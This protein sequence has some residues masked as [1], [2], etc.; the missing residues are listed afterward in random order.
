MA[1]EY[2]RRRPG[3]ELERDLLLMVKGENQRDGERAAAINHYMEM[4]WQRNGEV[5]AAFYQS[6]L[7]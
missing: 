7:S 5:E 3:H 2:A 6:D 1:G 4:N